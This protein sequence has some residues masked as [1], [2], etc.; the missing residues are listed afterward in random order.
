[1]RPTSQ[2][3]ATMPAVSPPQLLQPRRPEGGAAPP[4]LRPPPTTPVRPTVGPPTLLK[5]RPSVTPKP[6]ALQP[7]QPQSGPAQTRVTMPVVMPK[8]EL[9]PSTPALQ[10]SQPQSGLAQSRVTMP[11]VMPKPELKPSTPASRPPALGDRLDGTR[12]FQPQR[13]GLQSTA[14]TAPPEGRGAGTTLNRPDPHKPRVTELLRPTQTE[15]IPDDLLVN[16]DKSKKPFKKGRKEKV[17]AE[18]RRAARKLREKARDEKAAAARKEKEEIFE[19]GEEGMSLEQLADIIQVDPSEIVR[20]LF[21]KGITLSMNQVLDKNICKVVAAEYDILVLD[22]AEETVAEKGKKRTE[23][24]TDEDIDDLTPRP[25]VVTVMGHV[26]HGKTSLLDYIRKKR[27]AAGEAGGIT[28]SIGAYNTSVEVDGELK[29]ICFLDT[30]GHEAFSAMRARGAQQCQRKRIVGSHGSSKSSS[31]SSS[32][33]SSG[34]KAV[35]VAAA[36]APVAIEAKAAVTDLA[37]IIV[38]A[39]DG[40][41][42]QTREA[43]AHAQAAGVPI[44]VAINKVDKAGADV[45]RVKQEL[46]ELNLVAEEW[47]GSTPMVAVS[48][49][50]GTG[51]PDLLQA[52]TWMAEEQSLQANAKRAAQGTIIESHLDRKVGP[53]ATLLVQAGTLK[54]G[55][56]ISAGAAYGKVRTLRDDLGQPMQEAGPSIAV[57][58][59]G[60]GSCPMAGEEWGVVASESAAR[61]ISVKSLASSRN[62]RMVEMTGGGSMVTLSSLATVDEDLEALQKM[63]L[64]IKGDTMGVVEAIKNALSAL[65]QHSVTLRFLLSNAGD[66]SISDVDLAAASTGLVLGFNL[67][68]DTAVEEHAKRLGVKLMTYNVIYDLIDDVKAAME[69]KL[70][71]IDEKVFL[72]KGE[73]K[74]VFGTGKK[75]VA[76]CVVLNG[77]LQK[78]AFVIVKRGKQVVAEGKLIS[79]RRVK[80]NV[81][82]VPEGVECGVGME[83]FIEWQEKDTFECFQVSR[84]CGPG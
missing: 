20:S 57:Q 52:V 43:V 83:G 28:Q 11:V 72:G 49:K 8:P 23:F 14:I 9:K 62:Q 80:D 29:T 3:A 53:V 75:R 16:D 17:T 76:G 51:I 77:K 33:S 84:G 78:G 30:P 1:M 71:S 2:P 67:K 40:V 66:I 69:G 45:E 64:I 65:P 61:E 24:L 42:P 47:G 82:E 58:M 44:L 59:V 46:L 25:P 26:D 39:D 21:M 36:K 32:K 68:P 19:V 73:V 55:D 50:K 27:V 15:Q 37:I 54:V 56:I 7:S 79:L 60:L 63:N 13:G 10:P 81:D 70:R 5:P 22:K 41:R 34:S 38:A 74:A 12:Q 35:A 18:M 48:A 31:G 6:P 4:Q